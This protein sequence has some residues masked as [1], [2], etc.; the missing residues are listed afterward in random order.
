MRAYFDDLAS[1]AAASTD[2]FG[3]ELARAASLVAD[4]VLG[5]RKVLVFGNGG[6]ATQAQHF[7]AELVVRYVPGNR[8]ALPA[9]ALTSDVAVLTAGANDFGYES[10]FAR[11]VEALGQTGD[12][13]LALTTSGGSPNVLRA[14]DAARRAG[15]GTVF[16]TGEKGRAEAARWDVG[17][18]VPSTET[19]HVQELHLACLH[20]VCAAV[21]AEWSKRRR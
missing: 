10:V 13:A 18:V 4:A 7:A 14:L 19:A 12:V 11:Q 15:M 3:A 8:P 6:S 9:I 17:I 1:L 16:L 21:D 20:L 5:G 2:A